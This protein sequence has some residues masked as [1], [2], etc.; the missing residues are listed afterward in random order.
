MANRPV[1][2]TISAT[3][4]SGSGGRLSGKCGAGVGL[5]TLQAGTYSRRR[6]AK[7]PNTMTAAITVIT[8]VLPR[9]GFQIRTSKGMTSSHIAATRKRPAAGPNMNSASRLC[10]SGVRPYQ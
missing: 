10:S 7:L 9:A 8:R 3:P 5:A 4:G 2:A 1:H 6:S